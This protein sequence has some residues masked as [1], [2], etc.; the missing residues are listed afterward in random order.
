MKYS[1]RW[2]LFYSIEL[3]DWDTGCGTIAAQDLPQTG[4]DLKGAQAVPLLTQIPWEHNRVIILLLFQISE[5]QN[6]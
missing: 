5:N 6:A 4:S 3:S 2:Y 1:H